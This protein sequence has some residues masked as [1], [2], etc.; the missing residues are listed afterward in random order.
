[1]KKEKHIDGYFYT[2]EYEY[3]GRK[4]L[5]KSAEGRGMKA[6]IFFKDSNKVEFTLRYSFIKAFLLL[7]KAK[8]KI[9]KI[10]QS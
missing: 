10:S 8:F 3:K 2:S 7:E 4:I 6:H 9:D 1:M 5:I